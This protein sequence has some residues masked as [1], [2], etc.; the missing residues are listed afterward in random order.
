MT[1]LFATKRWEWSEQ[2]KTKTVHLE[3]RLKKCICLREFYK[4]LNTNFHNKIASPIKH[5]TC[6]IN[7]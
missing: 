2:H 6:L 4:I 1:D 7:K 3:V 5:S